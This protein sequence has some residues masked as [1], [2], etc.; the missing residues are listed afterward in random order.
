MESEV[1]ETESG[2]FQRAVDL[3]D[4]LLATADGGPGVS[5]GMYEASTILALLMDK[6]YRVNAMSRLDEFADAESGD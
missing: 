4:R 1:L 5:L 6:V 2:S 3:L